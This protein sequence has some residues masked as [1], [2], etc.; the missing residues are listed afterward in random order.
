MRIKQEVIWAK[1]CNLSPVR[2]IQKNRAQH[3]ALEIGSRHFLFPPLSDQ[4]ANLL[5]LDHQGTTYANTLD[6]TSFVVQSQCPVTSTEKASRLIEGKQ[7][8]YL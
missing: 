7:W 1:N 4:P 2:R 3:G 6:P 5:R 8:F